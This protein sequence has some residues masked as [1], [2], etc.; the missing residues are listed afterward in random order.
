[1]TFTRRKQERSIIRFGMR[2]SEEESIRLREDA[3]TAGLTMSELARRR[4]LG[5]PVIADVDATMLRELRRQGGLLKLTSKLLAQHPDVVR[6]C[7][8]AIRILR[9]TIERLAAGTQ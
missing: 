7:V 9:S 1:M 2:M 5:R 6:E 4:I 8:E 3:E